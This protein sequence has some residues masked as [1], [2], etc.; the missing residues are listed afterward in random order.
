LKDI[1]KTI[2]AP[3]APPARL[4]HRGAQPGSVWSSL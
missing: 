3:L 1:R 4:E 2:D